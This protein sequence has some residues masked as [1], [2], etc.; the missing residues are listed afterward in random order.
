[1]KPLSDERWLYCLIHIWKVGLLLLDDN[2]CVTEYF[3]LAVRLC[4]EVVLSFTQLERS[5]TGN[6]ARLSIACRSFTPKILVEEV[7]N[8]LEFSGDMQ[9]TGTLFCEGMC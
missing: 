9:Q 5:H 6:L 1:M 7:Y 8:Y 3:L 4:R 2:V